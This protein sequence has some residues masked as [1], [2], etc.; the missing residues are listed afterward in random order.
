[1][2]RNS[3]V[4]AQGDENVAFQNLLNFLDF[5]VPGKNG[6]VNNIFD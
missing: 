4:V 1:M 5:W 3:Y 2:H 6:F